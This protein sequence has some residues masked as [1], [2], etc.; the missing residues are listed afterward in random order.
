MIR[1][2]F[3]APGDEEDEIQARLRLL[4]LDSDSALQYNCLSYCVWG[5]P[6]FTHPAIINEQSQYP[7]Y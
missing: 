4:E 1:D 7:D 6:K 5:N 3:L 2:L